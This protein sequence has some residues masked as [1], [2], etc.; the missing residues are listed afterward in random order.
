MKYIIKQQGLINTDYEIYDEADNIAYYADSSNSLLKWDRNLYDC[1][2][3]KIGYIVEKSSGLKTVFEL[4]A[5]DVLVGT[6]VR[7]G[8]V[9]KNEFTLVDS[10]LN[11][12]GNFWGSHFELTNDEELVATIDL[13]AFSLKSV[14]EINIGDCYDPAI[15]LSIALAIEIMNRKAAA[16]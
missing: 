10:D 15:C 5:N 4:Y 3:Q 8:S 7:K 13:N 6:I 16:D 14:I 12:N 1:Y 9:F 11:I 2:Q